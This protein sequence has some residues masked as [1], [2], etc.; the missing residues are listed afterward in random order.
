MSLSSDFDDALALAS[1]LHR[2]QRRKGSETPYI[3]HVLAV[4]AIALEYGATESEAIAAVLHDAVEDQGGQKRLMKIRDQFGK[5]IARIVAGC[6][7]T[8]EKPK[9]PWPERKEA[10]VERLREATYSVRLVVAAD[11]VH[12]V[13]DVSASYQIHGEDFWSQF[14]GGRDGTLWYYR[15][16]VD[17]LW[18][19]AQPEEDRLIVLVAELDQ[20]VTALEEFAAERGESVVSDLPA[21]SADETM[22]T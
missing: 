12:N 5:R 8:T 18:S 13:R 17:A 3:A 9:P 10:F 1:R 15:A 11:K 22:G 21:A 7:D 6:S 19:A 20:A 4:T 14:N 2:K 16:V